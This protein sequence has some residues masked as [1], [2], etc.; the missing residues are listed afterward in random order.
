MLMRNIRLIERGLWYISAAHSEED[1]RICLSTAE[2]VLTEMS[3][4]RPNGRQSH[5]A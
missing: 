2:E 4:A 5:K 1:V 3:S